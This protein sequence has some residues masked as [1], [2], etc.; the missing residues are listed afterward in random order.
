[1]IA[2]R[3]VTVQKV[4]SAKEKKGKELRREKSYLSKEYRCLCSIH[5][6]DVVEL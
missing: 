2:R 4:K 5:P 6:I 3:V 1:M